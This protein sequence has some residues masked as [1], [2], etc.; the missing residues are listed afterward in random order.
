[1]LCPLNEYQTGNQRFFS[2]HLCLRYSPI[3]NPGGQ[4]HVVLNRCFTRR[5]LFLLF[6]SSHSLLFYLCSPLNPPEGRVHYLCL[7]WEDAS[8]CLVPRQAFTCGSSHCTVSSS[9]ARPDLSGLRSYPRTF[10][11]ATPPPLPTPTWDPLS[12]AI[13]MAGP[14]L[15]SR[16]HFT[17]HFSKRPSVRTLSQE[18]PQAN[19]LLLPAF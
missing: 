1:M 16:S 10:A 19:C 9:L 8:G 13:P 12:F 7:P 3:I 2:R 5:P 18:D 17:R 6:W 4:G 15:S 14:S 11:L